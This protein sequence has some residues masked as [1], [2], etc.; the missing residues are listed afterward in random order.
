MHGY[1]PFTVDISELHAARVVVV[2]GGHQVI[3][4]KRSARTI[5]SRPLLL[6]TVHCA[7]N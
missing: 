5:G 3:I 7:F 1:D 2:E 6:E 4:C